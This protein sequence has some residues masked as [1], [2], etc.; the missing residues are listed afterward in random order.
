MIRRLYAALLLAAPGAALA[1]PVCGGP[2]E[3]EQV[4][5]AFVNTTIFLSAVPLLMIGG[6]VWWL[7]RRARQMDA[8]EQPPV[9]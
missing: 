8:E 3:K 6:G 7:F 2:A 9:Q 5:Q 1:C 4:Q